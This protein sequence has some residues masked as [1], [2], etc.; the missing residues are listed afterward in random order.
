MLANPLTPELASLASDAAIE[1]DLLINGE[2]T[3]LA[4]VRE[5]ASFLEHTSA[6]PQDAATE[7]R[8]SVD[9]ATETILGRA[10]VQTGADH[11]NIIEN[12]LKKTREVAADLNTADGTQR[13]DSLEWTRAFCLALSQSAAAYRQLFLG[14]RPENPYRR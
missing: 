4:A 8:L 1:L 10:F 12:L 3:D 6:E 7:R 2:E 5:L 14:A 9:M 13:P 11:T